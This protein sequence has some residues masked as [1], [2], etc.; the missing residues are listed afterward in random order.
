M[1]TGAIFARGSCRALKWVA[2]CMVAT[3]LGAVQAQAQT[4]GTIEAGE[5]I[6]TPG[7]NTV[8]ITPGGLVGTAAAAATV[9]A[10][11]AVNVRPTTGDPA[12]QTI[13]SIA[14]GSIGSPSSTITLTLSSNLNSGDDVELVYTQPAAPGVGETDERIALSGAATFVPSIAATDQFNVWEVDVPPVPPSSVGDLRLARGRPMDP[15]V[16]PSGSGGNGDLDYSL[17]IGA[18]ANAVAWANEATDIA[19]TTTAKVPGLTWDS[20]ARLLYGTPTGLDLTSTPNVLTGDVTLTYRT[21]DNALATGRPGTGGDGQTIDR[22]FKITLVAPGTPAGTGTTLT[23]ATLVIDAQNVDEGT[24]NDVD[25]VLS[26]EVPANTEHPTEVKVTVMVD[27]LTDATALAALRATQAEDGDFTVTDPSTS[28]ADPTMSTVTFEFPANTSRNSVRRTL[29]QS[30][31]LQTLNHD[32]DAEDEGIRLSVTNVAAVSVISATNKPTSMVHAANGSTVAATPRNIKIDDD[33]TQTYT[34]KLKQGTSVGKEGTDTTLVAEAVPVHVDGSATMS[35]HIVAD[36]PHNEYTVTPMVTVGRS[37]GTLDNDVDVTVTTPANDGN[38]SADAV[39]VTMAAGTS[40]NPGAGIVWTG[41]VADAHALPSVTAFA[42]DANGSDSSPQPTQIDEGQTLTFVLRTA[43]AVEEDIRV[44]LEPGGDADAQDLGDYRLLQSLAIDHGN[45]ESTPFELTAVEDDDVGME[46]LILTAVVTGEAM[47]GT[48]SM[49]NEAATL[50]IVDKTMKQVEPKSV[51]AIDQA[52]ADAMAV[53]VGDEGL[54]PTES[55]EVMGTDLFMLATGYTATYAASSNDTA[56]VRASASGGTVTL[57][58]NSAGT[59]TVTVTANAEMAS[60]VTTTSQTVADRATVTFDVTVADKKLVVTVAA[61]PM[62]IMEGGMS[63]ITATANRDVLASDGEVKVDLEVIG[64]GEL[65]AS[66]ITIAADSMMNTAT[67]TAL[68]D[69]DD[70][71]NETLTVIARGAAAATIEIAV[72]D[73]DEAPA[74]PAA[75]TAK[76]QAEVDTAVAA[77]IDEVRND[78]G[79]LGPQRSRH[80]HEQR[81]RSDHGA[82]RFR[83]GCRARDGPEYEFELRRRGRVGA[84]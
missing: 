52:V 54:N 66:S 62:E 55:F 81:A 47:Y 82:V 24:V 8:L 57:T 77:A 58:A 21:A 20:T 32:A 80:V 16:L 27:P 45:T 65:S 69:D 10:D 9:M 56:V 38:R 36:P 48:D 71:E 40:S 18:G 1:R 11:F 14:I 26:A 50:A 63:T 30:F 53:S 61:D 15:T 70:Y 25:V 64:D 28:N 79:A 84:H 75:V 43:A 22:T 19:G 2:A 67:V 17:F 13:T 60:G 78:E 35:L 49:S 41:S 73:N 83:R 4:A 44:A 59:A 37:G 39:T 23:N 12:A 74:V 68:E 5:A 46:E 29:T 76:S 6:F 3:A 42:I 34:L 72:I 31:Q 51:A 7:S 33:E